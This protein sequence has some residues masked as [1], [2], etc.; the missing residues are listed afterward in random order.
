MTEITLSNETVQYINLASKYS[1]ARIIDCVLD[2]GKL[3]F[4]VEKGQL[5]LAIGNKARNLERLRTIFK[6]N[7]RFIEFDED[8]KKFIYNLCKPYRVLNIV[9]EEGNN[10]CIAKIE[11]DQRDKSK[12]IGKD[13]R[14]INL[15]RKIAQRH[16][17]FK[18]VQIL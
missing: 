14:N 9:I 17:P 3:V 13:G 1:K 12:I 4:V 7:I 16:H 8:K 11:V 5:G 10:G 6:K 15:I 2:E 18:D